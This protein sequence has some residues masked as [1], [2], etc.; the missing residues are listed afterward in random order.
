MRRSNQRSRWATALLCAGA[1]SVLAQSAAGSVLDNQCAY[2]RSLREGRG[3]GGEATSCKIARST[4]PRS[5]DDAE[6]NGDGQRSDRNRAALV[7]A[8][9]ELSGDP[10]DDARFPADRQCALDRKARRALGLAGDPASCRLE[11]ATAAR[12]GTAQVARN[13]AALSAQLSERQS[14]DFTMCGVLLCLAAPN[15]PDSIAGWAPYL[16]KFRS[17]QQLPACPMVRPGSVPEL[18]FAGVDRNGLPSPSARS[19]ER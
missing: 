3:V 8:E 9:A 6:D 18:E 1:G 7:A 13:V 5:T 11:D 16:G 10:E 19:R 12:P 15:D 17:R 2:E 4:Q 14:D